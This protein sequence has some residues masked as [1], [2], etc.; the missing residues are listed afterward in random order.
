MTKNPHAWVRPD[1]ETR[2]SAHLQAW[3]T[4]KQTTARHPLEVHPFI[5]ISR[6]YGCEGAALAHRLVD[7]LNERCRPSFPWV[8][9]DHELFNRI[10]HEPGLR[11]E[12]IEALESRRRDQMSKLLN[13][14]L[15]KKADDAPEMRQLAEVVRSLAL[16]GRAVLMGRGSYLIT[17]DLK[18]ALHV[19]LIAPL[20]WR[21]LRVA[22]TRELGH[23]EARKIVAEGEKQRTHYLHTHFVQH[24]EHVI[25]P[26]LVIDNSRF[27]LV[28]IGEIVFTAL[29][30]RLGKTPRA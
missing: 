14:I 20:D 9:Y 24:P 13:T 29:S 23:A 7:V 5:T 3:K 18:T 6:E 16:H 21:A 4:F 19:R 11:R 30:A 17:Q 22:T 28:Q 1:L 12:V 25:T 27:N 8:A 10:S 15:N 26:D 2:L